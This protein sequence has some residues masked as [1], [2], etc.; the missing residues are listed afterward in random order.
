M[1]ISFS[2]DK[3]RQ[4]IV[5]DEAGAG[6][7]VNC[8]KCRAPLGVPYK[9]KSVESPPPLLGQVAEPIPES[10]AA[11]AV[12]R[13]PKA[14]GVVVLS[15]LAICAFLAY[16]YENSDADF[17]AKMR[18]AAY[19]R[20]ERAAAEAGDARAQYN[21][22]FDYE[23]GSGV[24]EDSAQAAK[25]YRKAAEQGHAGAQYKLGEFYKEGKGV[26]QDY[27]EAENWYR[28]AAESY[29]KL[30][31]Q[32]DTHAQISLGSLYADGLGVK[33]DYAQALKWYRRA[34]EQ[35]RGWAQ[36]SAEVRLGMCYEYGNGV[37]RDPVEAYKWYNLASAGGDR[38]AALQRDQVAGTM[39]AEQI[40]EGQR[41]ASESA[42]R[43]RN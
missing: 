36:H 9:S 19:A 21:L 29:G 26:M 40:A 7:L 4:Q 24:Q 17:W 42:A 16:E 6:Q 41:R 8:P 34:A 2:C 35:G 31:E 13:L 3:C 25:W 28:K 32:G 27:A 15:V 5:I 14:L 12:G 39:T 23:L 43:K 11:K 37:E 10:P 1:D 30:A 22:A 38:V 20:S 18:G 33:Q